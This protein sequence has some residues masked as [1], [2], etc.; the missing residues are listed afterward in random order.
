M[1]NT[2]NRRGFKG[3]IA[4][5]GAVLLAASLSI[6]ALADEGFDGTITVKNVVA[7]YEY[8]VYKVLECGVLGMGDTPY[9]AE[10]EWKDFLETNENAIAI[11]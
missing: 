10:E 8:K 4:T 11:L 2:G 9:T 3:F 1:K 5:L 7:G 6:T